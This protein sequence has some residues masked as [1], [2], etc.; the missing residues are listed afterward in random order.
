MEQVVDVDGGGGGGGDD[1]L[2]VWLKEEREETKATGRD[3]NGSGGSP[4][5]TTS[6]GGPPAS[7]GFASAKTNVERWAAEVGLS[8]GDT[9][10]PGPR[11]W[12][13]VAE[14]GQYMV[15]F[16]PGWRLQSSH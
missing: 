3:G 12:S 8:C 16:L 5:G 11:G 13:A 7:G 2:V 14:L 15:P 6:T 10:Q 1:G 9:G 4:R